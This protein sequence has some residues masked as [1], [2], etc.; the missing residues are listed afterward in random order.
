MIRTSDILT[1]VSADRSIFVRLGQVP[2]GLNVMFIKLEKTNGKDVK[3][4]ISQ[5]HNSVR[6][7]EVQNHR[8]VRISRF[9]IGNDP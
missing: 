1:M 3:L 2:A 9:E 6:N 7:V 5:S 8:V 4:H